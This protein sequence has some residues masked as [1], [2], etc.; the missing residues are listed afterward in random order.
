MNAE[1][2]MR[3]QHAQALLDGLHSERCVGVPA[4]LLEHARCSALG[5]R[6][7]ARAALRAAP[8]VFAPDHERWQAWSEAEDWLHWP[9]ATLETF[10]RELGAIA[11]GPALRVAVERSEVLFLR[12]AFGLDAWRRAQA[13]D[14]W[15]GAAPEA[16][17][18]MGRAVMQ[19]CERDAQAL[20]DAVFERG[21]IE[22]LGHAGRN[23]ARLAERLALAY[24]SAPALPCIKECWLPAG[25]VAGLLVS[26]R[27]S[28]ETDVAEAQPE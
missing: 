3:R 18:H 26:S 28:D 9:H 1:R 23:D 11:F 27:A 5:R 7:L 8:A 15:R 17:R 25:T 22:F 12:E 10:T 20:R 19:R 24:A 4:D 14:P 6:H 13:A 2:A 16:V 21:K